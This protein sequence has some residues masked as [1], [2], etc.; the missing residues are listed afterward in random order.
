MLPALRAR[1]ARPSRSAG[2]VS[3]ENAASRLAPMPSNAEPV[4]SAATMVRKR[5]SPNR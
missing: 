2:S 1:A 5:I 4:S 3:A